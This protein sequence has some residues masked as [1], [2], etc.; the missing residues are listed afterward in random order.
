MTIERGGRK[1]TT[2]PEAR[3][4]PPQPAPEVPLPEVGGTGTPDLE[5]VG[6]DEDSILEQ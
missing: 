6:R 3:A 4:I 2:P 1:G 5:V